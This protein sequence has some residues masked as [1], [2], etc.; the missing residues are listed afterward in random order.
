MFFFHFKQRKTRKD[1]KK[2][3]FW[4]LSVIFSQRYANIPFQQSSPS[5]PGSIRADSVYFVLGEFF[6]SS[7][8][9]L[10]SQS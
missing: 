1:T 9:S 2:M 5:S 7:V 10:G 6:G 4:I 3:A 8:A